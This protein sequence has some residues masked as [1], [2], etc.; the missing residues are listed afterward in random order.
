[1]AV[2]GQVIF[3]L[4]DFPE[5]TNFRK[6][7]LQSD[8][9]RSF[10][11]Y[12]SQKEFRYL[13]LDRFSDDFADI[14]MKNDFKKGGKAALGNVAGCDAPITAFFFSRWCSPT[15]SKRLVLEKSHRSQ[16]SNSI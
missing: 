14:D 5:N 10:R 15:S 1:L 11:F 9:R 6:G 12:S 8:L 16:I 4:S 3:D 2:N 7:L 13:D